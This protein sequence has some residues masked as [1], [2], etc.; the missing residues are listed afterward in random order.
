MRMR[1]YGYFRLIAYGMYRTSRAS[2]S[3]ERYMFVPMTE[4]TFSYHLRSS[5]IGHTFRSIEGRGKHVVSTPKRPTCQ[6][7]HKLEGEVA[8]QLAL[9]HRHLIA[10]HK[11]RHQPVQEL[12]FKPVVIFL[13][14]LMEKG[15]ADEVRSWSNGMTRRI[16]SFTL[17]C[18]SLPQPP[19]SNS[20]P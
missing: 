18:L 9:K 20:P 4:D 7:D 10:R 8:N 17:K 3:Y 2:L 1:Q 6:S 13:G 19:R 12:P 14:G 11:T 5:T 15:T 16:H